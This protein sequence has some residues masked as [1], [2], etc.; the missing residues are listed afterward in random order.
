VA[1]RQKNLTAMRAFQL[2]QE[3]GI[4]DP[5]GEVLQALCDAMLI[6]SGKVASSSQSRAGWYESIPASWWRH[7]SRRI[8]DD[9]AYFTPAETNPPTP[10]RVA[11]IEFSK[12]SI[13]NLWPVSETAELTATSERVAEPLQK[14]ACLDKSGR[15][16]GPRPEKLAATI[17]AMHRDIETGKLDRNKLDTSTEEA[18]KAD[19]GVSRETVRK[20][21]VRVLDSLR[22]SPGELR[23][24]T[25]SDK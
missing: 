13:D 4:H 25:N 2:L 6:A 10:F 7:I 15:R 20:A 21:R 8:E 1:Y 11:E 24:S 18:L 3:R 12:E 14:A 9:V 23:T 5:H 16:R 22:P 17:R 19:Y